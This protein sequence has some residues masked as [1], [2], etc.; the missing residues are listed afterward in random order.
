MPSAALELDRRPGGGRLEIVYAE[1][2]GWLTHI[3]EETPDLGFFGQALLS[4]VKNEQGRVIA[5]AEPALSAVF[6]GTR[7]PGRWI[8]LPK[9]PR[10]NKQAEVLSEAIAIAPTLASPEWHD[11]FQVLGLVFEEEVRQGVLED[12]WVFLVS[13]AP[14]DPSSG[15]PRGT[16]VRGMRYS[17]QDLTERVPELRSLPAA[18]VSILGLGT[19]GS[20]VAVQLAKSQCGTLRLGDYDFV[21][22][23]TGVRWSH[24]L[25]AAGGLKPFV[26]KTLLES[27]YPYVDIEAHTL[28]IGATPADRAG[29]SEID[30]LDAWSADSSL[31]IDAS[32]EQNVRRV[33][34]YLAHPRKI[35]QVYVW[36][37]DGYGGVVALIEPGRTGCLLCLERALSPTSGFI[38]PPTAAENQERTRVQPRG[39]ADRTF[40]GAL[41]DLAPL[42]IEASRMALAVLAGGDKNVYPKPPQ[43]VLIFSVRNS[44]GT[45]R[46]PAWTGYE[47]APDV[48]SC[49]LCARA[50]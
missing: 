3:F 13:Q 47:L 29:P 50:A 9:A 27:D 24:G 43:P 44:D 6:S 20:D 42:S 39:C 35:P 16:F 17:P 25:G 36:S 21:E 49:D 30:L 4:T 23:A 11:G 7:W 10:S 31:I 15:G 48:E 5:Q 22:A 8:R 2:A 12:T 34:A 28:A 38:T 26:L 37:V 14:K 18:K 19:L 32:A 45:L 46:V 40:T 33:I 1:D 41:V